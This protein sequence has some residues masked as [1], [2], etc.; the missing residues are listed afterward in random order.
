MGNARYLDER[1]CK[2]YC[3]YYSV[4]VKFGNYIGMVVYWTVRDSKGDFPKMPKK[5][6][7]E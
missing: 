4:C 7:E 1:D 2:K 5:E 6:T 3:D